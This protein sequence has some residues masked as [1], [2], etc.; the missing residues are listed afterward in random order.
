MAGDP[1]ND[2]VVTSETLTEIE[3][4]RAERGNVPGTCTRT[5]VIDGLADN[6]DGL[7]LRKDHIATKESPYDNAWMFRVF[8]EPKPEQLDDGFHLREGQTLRI[9]EIK[10]PASM[11]DELKALSVET[12]ARVRVTVEVMD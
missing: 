9:A 2:M 11:L 10:L 12:A 5:L 1:E 4:M 8:E 3:R 6:Y 7:T